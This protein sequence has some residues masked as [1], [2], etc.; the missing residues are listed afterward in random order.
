[1]WKMYGKIHPNSKRSINQS[2]DRMYTVRWCIRAAHSS[3]EISLKN[4]FMYSWSWVSVRFGYIWEYK[5]L[6]NYIYIYLYKNVELIFIRGFV[7]SS[8]PLKLDDEEFPNPMCW[9]GRGRSS[10]WFLVGAA[11]GE[12]AA[13]IWWME[14]MI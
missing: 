8:P 13:M 11:W 2:L 7:R 9:Q 5:L 4:T 3:H 14:V 6:R 10:Q 1:M 12:S